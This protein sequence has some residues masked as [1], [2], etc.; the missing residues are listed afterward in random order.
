MLEENLQL[1]QANFKLCTLIPLRKRNVAW[2]ASLWVCW[3]GGSGL[4]E[5]KT[6]TVLKHGMY[7]V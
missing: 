7:S 6:K 5:C 4:H 2:R 1:I 3:T